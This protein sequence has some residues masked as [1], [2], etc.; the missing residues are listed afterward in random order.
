MNVRELLEQSESLDAGKADHFTEVSDVVFTS[1]GGMQ[2]AESTLF[3]ISQSE[4]TIEDH[5]LGQICDKLGP[6]PRDYIR[7][8]PGTLQSINL[9]Y[10]ADKNDKDWMV[11]SAD[12]AARAVVS[13]LYAPVDN[14]FIIKTLVDFLGDTTHKLVGQSTVTRDELHARVALKADEL[15]IPGQDG[16]ELYLAGIYFGNSEIGTKSV[17]I[18]PFVQRT[19]CENST[20]WVEGGIVQRHYGVETKSFIKGLIKEKLGTLLG[21]SKEMLERIV[22]A[23]ME[24]IEDPAVAIERI[25]KAHGL[26]DLEEYILIG[27]E[28]RYSTMGI[29]HG[30]TS[31]ANTVEDPSRQAHIQEIAGAYLFGNKVYTE[32]DA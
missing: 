9:N 10:W 17:R 28:G 21:K 4:L 24:T 26:T 27:T 29:V 14:T 2:L 7:K 22:E 20:I 30:L 16:K 18:S 32:S 11:R 12:G 23:E 6:P 1:N 8:C 5:A 13:G 25:A 31:A 3:G 19:S 15:D